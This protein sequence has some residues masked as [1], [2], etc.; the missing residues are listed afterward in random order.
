MPDHSDNLHEEFQVDTS[1]R[2]YQVTVY[3]EG[4]KII[5]IASWSI[6]TRSSS[7][8]AS[9]FLHSLPLDRL[10]LAKPHLYDRSSGLIIDEPDFIIVN[11]QRIQ[12]I[13]A[14]EQTDLES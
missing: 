4:L 13:Y 5:G 6:D 12:A 2:Q 9:D 10:T 3:T 7:R 11:M 1:G 14:V 8:R